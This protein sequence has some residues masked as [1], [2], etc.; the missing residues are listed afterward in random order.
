[1]NPLDA[2]NNLV[3]QATAAPSQ[4]RWLMCRECGNILEH[5]MSQLPA[6][7]PCVCGAAFNRVTLPSKELAEAKRR[8]LRA[9]KGLPLTPAEHAQVAAAAP[10]E[11]AA[12]NNE[13]AFGGPEK[14]EIPAPKAPEKVE[15]AEAPKPEPKPRRGR[16]AKGDAAAIPEPP[17][18]PVAE[19]SKPQPQTHSAPVLAPL[20]ANGLPENLVQTPAE[21]VDWDAK[22]AADKAAFVAK[23]GLTETAWAPCGHG[24]LFTTGFWS[25]RDDGTRFVDW[26]ELHD[27]PQSFAARYAEAKAR[28]PKTTADQ[29]LINDL[30]ADFTGIAFRGTVTAS[31]RKVLQSCSVRP[32]YGCRVSLAAK[33]TENGN[34][35]F[36]VTAVSK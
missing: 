32:T 15:P 22:R 16:A 36:Q 11:V 35:S 1:M 6:A 34:L 19:P 18:A 23:Y 27:T 26:F 9:A 8:E 21:D 31:L 7:D 4:L 28:D 25:T 20:N 33:L 17:V 29:G 13:A 24:R 3:N 30:P 10:S 5:D 14:V 2:I 12:A